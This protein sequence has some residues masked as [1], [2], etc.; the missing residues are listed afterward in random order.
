MRTGRQQVCG[1]LQGGHSLFPSDR[2]KVIEEPLIMGSSTNF[3]RLVPAGTSRA[4]RP[5]LGIRDVSI[6]LDDRVSRRQKL[7]VCQSPQDQQATL[8]TPGR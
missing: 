7:D 3:G 8:G 1:D 5:L 2:R 6:C 4:F